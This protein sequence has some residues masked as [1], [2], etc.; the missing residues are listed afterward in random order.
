[1]L[2]FPLAIPWAI[3]LSAAG[4]VVGREQ[5]P[6][7]DGWSPAIGAG[8]LLAAELAAWSIDHDRRIVSERALVL[9]DAAR[10]AVLVAAAGLLGFVLVG[11]AAVS[12]A[13]GLLLT[14][15]GVVAA[16]SAVGVI[17]RLAQD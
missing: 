10:L 13:A 14:A 2:R 6:T 17:L 9:R 12:S 1:V 8:L 5:H 7:V 11:A 3:G 16:V 4:Y 15:I